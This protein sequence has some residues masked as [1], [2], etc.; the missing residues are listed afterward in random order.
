[1]LRY[2]LKPAASPIILEVLAP[3]LLRRVRR[4]HGV[5]AKLLADL[6]KSFRIGKAA[7]GD[8]RT[9]FDKPRLG[10]EKSWQALTGVK[11][12]QPTLYQRSGNRRDLR[13][14]RLTRRR[15]MS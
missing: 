14:N 7:V 10:K 9:Q 13:C 3:S 12:H 2:R 4:G 1:M 5:D 11:P 15:A 8:H 6:G